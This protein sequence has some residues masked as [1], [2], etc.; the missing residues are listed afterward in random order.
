MK[1]LLLASLL[2]L[3]ASSLVAAPFSISSVNGGAATGSTK[4]NFDDFA[5]GNTGGTKGLVTL[6]FTGDGKVVT[7]FQSGKYAR[8]FLSGGNG[9]GFGPGG[10]NQAN[11][12]DE[13]KYVT[14]GVGSATL[15]FATDQKYFGLLWGSVDTY[16]SLWFYDDNA[17][18]GSLTGT[19]VWAS[20]NGNQG[21]QGTYYVNITFANGFKFDKVVAKSSG[22]AFEFDNVAYTS[23]PDAAGTLGLI[24]A[25]LLGLVAFRRR[26]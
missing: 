26:G 15:S 11:G 13:T 9:M 25:A 2:A 17:L 8:P 10:T 20:A 3:G 21:A 4:L 23:V 22:Y 18:V 19:N 24:G 16:N 14:T 1:N 7:G 12:V 6:S 5:L